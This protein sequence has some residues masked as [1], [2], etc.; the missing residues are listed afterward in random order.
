MNNLKL[1]LQEGHILYKSARATNHPFTDDI[2]LYLPNIM[3]DIDYDEDEMWK[4]IDHLVLIELICSIVTKEINGGKPLC[5]GNG[6]C[7]INQVLR[8]VQLNHEVKIQ[9][10]NATIKN[11]DIKKKEV[12][13]HKISEA[14][15]TAAFAYKIK[16]LTNEIRIS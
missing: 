7:P 16:E 13:K 5:K 8:K 3:K 1:I 9:C 2:V 12:D 10:E 4:A 6:K 14:L 11:I 15:T